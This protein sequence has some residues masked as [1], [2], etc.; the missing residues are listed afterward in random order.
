MMLEIFPLLPEPSA[1][2]ELGWQAPLPSR[3]LTHPAAKGSGPGT[4][5][6]DDPVSHKFHCPELQVLLGPNER[7]VAESVL[8]AN[9]L[10]KD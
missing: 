7:K 4:K 3:Q 9:L 5:N 1:D 8:Q 10:S 2:S 6:M